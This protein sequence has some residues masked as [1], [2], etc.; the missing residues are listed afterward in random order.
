MPSRERTRL[1]LWAAS[2]LFPLACVGVAL[3]VLSGETSSNALLVVLLGAA[4]IGATGLFSAPTSYPNRFTVSTGAAASLPFLLL[5]DISVDPPVP[6]PHRLPVVVAA[7]A[8]GLA[9]VWVLSAARGDRPVR[10]LTGLVRQL[11]GFSVYATVFSAVIDT[12]LFASMREDWNQ[13]LP[14]VVGW[15]AWLALDVIVWSLVAFGSRQLSFRYMALEGLKDL[16]VFVGLVASGALF[17]MAYPTIGWWALAVAVLPY[18]FAH[19]AFRRFQATKRT[20]RQT[21]RA[22]ARIPEVAGLS[23]DGH[24]DR[25]AELA[26]AISKEMGLAPSEVDE[27]EYAALMHDIGRITLNE[28]SIVRMGYTE[29]DIARWGAEIIAEAAYLNRVADIVRRQ[30]EPYRKPGEERDPELPLAAQIIRAASAYDQ[31]VSEQAQTP[32]QAIENLHRGAAYDFDPL[33]V[34]SLRRVLE[35]RGVFSPSALTR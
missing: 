16:D 14:L 32:L 15:L 12:Q 31:A 19:G 11:A 1:W 30:N 25:T 3:W 7:Y 20:Y 18:A 22:L 26:V 33:V 24:A 6:T 17:G 4:S 23:A 28:P 2:A 8:A 21:I 10:L 35:A 5:F 34:A 9:L 13:I 29:E 27:V